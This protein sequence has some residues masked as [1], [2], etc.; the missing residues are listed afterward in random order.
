MEKSC[1]NCKYS[2]EVKYNELVSELISKGKIIP[3]DEVV[4]N[5]RILFLYNRTFPSDF[6]CR[7]FERRSKK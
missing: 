2:T 1:K 5:K 6:Y 4:C 7:Y 3:N